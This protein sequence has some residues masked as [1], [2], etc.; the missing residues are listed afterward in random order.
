MKADVWRN[1]FDIGFIK[2][3]FFFFPDLYSTISLDVC[4]RAHACLYKS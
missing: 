1:G 3:I 4:V 2:N